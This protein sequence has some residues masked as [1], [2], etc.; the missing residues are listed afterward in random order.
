M[1]LRIVICVIV[2]ELLARFLIDAQR[3]NYSS[4]GLRETNFLLG[5]CI[6]LDV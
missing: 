6:A 2:N 4:G 5:A 1:A 3:T